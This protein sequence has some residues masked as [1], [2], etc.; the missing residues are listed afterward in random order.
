[1]ICSSFFADKINMMNITNFAK[2]RSGHL[3]RIGAG[4]LFVAL[5]ALAGAAPPNAAKP[6]TADKPAPRSLSNLKSAKTPQTTLYPVSAQQT[7]DAILAD[8]LGRVYEQ[9]D[10]HFHKGEYSH[11]VNLYR[12][13]TQGDPHNVEA[14]GVSA[15]LLWSTDRGD[16]A[17]DML[18]QGVKAN[19]DTYYMYDEIGTHYW[20]R[21]RDA[22]TALPYYEQA[23]KHP[24][25]A[26]STWHNLAHCYRKTKQWD[27]A[28]YA[29]ERAMNYPDDPV[30]RVWLPR[31]RAERDQH[32]GE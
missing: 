28:V 14:Y 27:K 6:Q 31:A 15:W 10:A 29:W 18:K 16:Q 12:I 1:M 20:I 30:A 25:C 7:A 8:S 26:A 24:D 5:P 21:L 23:V 13:V 11:V 32:K 19:P 22:A 2:Q 3:R 9:G 17:I 4:M